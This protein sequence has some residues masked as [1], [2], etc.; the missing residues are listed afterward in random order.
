MR[1]SFG[2]YAEMFKNAGNLL[3]RNKAFMWKFSGSP[4]KWGLN[5]QTHIWFRGVKSKHKVLKEDAHIL[6]SSSSV[7][8]GLLFAFSS[9]LPHL[10]VL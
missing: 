5:K 9:L 6:F 1:L 8:T 3:R 7:N 10:Q 4:G 2:L